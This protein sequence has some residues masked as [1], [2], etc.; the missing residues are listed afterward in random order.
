MLLSPSGDD[1]AFVLVSGLTNVRDVQLPLEVRLVGNGS[2]QLVVGKIRT[3]NSGGEGGVY[4]PFVEPLRGFSA[5][6][7]RDTR[8]TV[9]LRGTLS[10]YEPAS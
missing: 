2:R 5:V 1:L 4:R 10:V 6:V 3:L 8:G 9:L 7:I